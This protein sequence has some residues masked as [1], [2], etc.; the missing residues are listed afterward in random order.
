MCGAD[1]R[2]TVVVPSRGRPAELARCVTSILRSDLQDFVLVVVEQQSGAGWAELPQDRRLNHL[3]LSSSGK[4]IAI[5]AGL[6][7]VTDGLVFFTDDDC[8]AEPSWLSRGRSLFYS[9]PTIGAIYSPLH[10]VPHDR[11]QE[12]IPTFEPTRNELLAGRWAFLHRPRGAGANLA[13]RKGLL[14]DVGA[15]DEQIGPG[16]ALPG[17]EEFDYLYRMLRRGASVLYDVSN[18]ILHWG[19]RRY[20][21]HSAQ[22][23]LCGYRRGQGAILAKHLKRGDLRTLGMLGRDTAITL[24]SAARATLTTGRPRRVR[25]WAHLIRGFGA[26]LRQPVDRQSGLFRPRGA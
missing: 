1:E 15:F 17:S 23:L 8:T 2:I 7:L 13:I 5:N 3:K 21:D 26:G 18:P 9:N 10:A 24:S 11:S 20:D 16:T 4:S 14:D 19:V 6:R 22:Q 12:W 25:P